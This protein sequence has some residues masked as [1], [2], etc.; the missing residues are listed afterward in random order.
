MLKQ[1]KLRVNVSLKENFMASFKVAVGDVK[2]DNN[3]VIMTVGSLIKSIPVIHKNEIVWSIN[4]RFA[5]SGT[6]GFTD[7]IYVD[8]FY[9][10]LP[11]QVQEFIILHELGHIV[12]KHNLKIKKPFLQSC[13]RVFKLSD[14]EVEADNHALKNLG[15]KRCYEA[16]TYLI[17]DVNMPYL[18]RKEL[19]KRLNRLQDL[20]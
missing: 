19:K 7:V 12:N 9:L 4:S 13:K 8:D 10:Y 16:L 20:N 5:C 15:H 11:K 17:H 18:S 1:E 14:L 6:L 2:V 3:D